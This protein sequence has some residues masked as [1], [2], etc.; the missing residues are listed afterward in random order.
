MK[1]FKYFLI[2]FVAL[3]LI[4]LSNCN[5]REHTNPYDSETPKELYTPENFTA[6]QEDSIVKLSWHQENKNIDGFIIKRQV[7]NELMVEIAR[8]DN[9]FETWFDNQVEFEQTYKY[10]LTSYAG[11]NISNP[12]VSEVTLWY[13]PQLTTAP[14]TQISATTA[15]I[16][17]NISSPGASSVSARGICWNTEENPTI[18]N[19][20][21]S[22]GVGIGDFESIL[23]GLTHETTYYA[24]SYATNS[25]GTAYGNQV[26][27]TTIYAG[28]PPSVET[29]EISN[30][31]HSFAIAVGVVTD[32]GGSSVAA[33][34][35]C[36]STSQSPDLSDSFTID[37][38]G[39]GSFACSMAE[40]SPET[41]YFVRAYA[42]NNAGTAYGNELS[43]TTLEDPSPGAPVNISATPGLDKVTLKWNIVE[44][45]TTY[46][47]YWSY[48]PDVSKANYTGVFNDINDIP[49]VHSGL[50]MN[51]TFY[52]VVTAGNNY[53]ESPESTIA[54]ATTFLL[55][56]TNNMT[57][58]GQKHYYQATV[59]NG[60]KLF[61][62]TN[63]ASHHQ[64]F[65]L[66][67]K[68]DSLP[69]TTNYDYSSKTNQDEAINITNTQSGTYY[70]M[71]Y[72]DD[73]ENLVTGSYTITGSTSVI[74]L[75]MESTY[76]AS[77]S[78]YEEKDYYE[79]TTTSGQ[80][81]FLNVHINETYNDFYLYVKHGSLPTKT[82]YDA[83][84]ATGDDEAINISNTE[85]GTYYIMVLAH[86]YE[87]LVNGGY[88]IKAEL[89]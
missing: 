6:V 20:V 58:N 11:V 65:H 2:P 73:Y 29:S 78:H 46:N 34:G 80:N 60:E 36:W 13:L 81:L 50:A 28:T 77:M 51:T 32:E 41:T 63:I 38:P 57:A 71:V 7:D 49:F 85:T 74:A 43:F 61:I 55:Y 76:N 72:A 62:T 53:G 39:S 87:N 24:R 86:D 40:L 12:V 22:N 10:E 66:Y 79:V 83:I 25:L 47:V 52:Y 45:A 59:T 37:G 84:S 42:T 19:S 15:T 35:V 21:T 69:T 48:N 5:K 30:F 23:T 88:N 68:Y 54:K 70:I 89:W 27:F 33:R 9:S 14:A 8:I 26:S 56:E 64:A 16:S 18:D 4:N 67:I 3:C 82:D 31:N 75:T 17:A 1:I 44:D